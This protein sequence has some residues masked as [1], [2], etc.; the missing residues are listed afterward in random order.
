MKDPVFIVG[1]PR[2][3]TS[4]IY[5]T[6]MKHTEFQS[7]EICLEETGIFQ[8]SLVGHDLWMKQKNLKRYF[9]DEEGFD[10]FV[11]EYK[12]RFKY[13]IFLSKIPGSRQIIKRI[14]FLWNLTGNIQIIQLFFQESVKA[15]RCNRIA[16][17][18][19]GHLHYLTRILKAFPD[20]KFLIVVRHPIDVYTSY[21]RRARA[22]P[23][24]KWLAVSQNFFIKKYRKC[25]KDTVEA[26][27]NY[28]GNV[29]LVSYEDF[30]SSPDKK[31]KDIC[32]FLNIEFEN[33]PINGGEKSFNS[34]KPDPYLAKPISKETK[35]WNDYI[36]REEALNIERK[37]LNEMNILSYKQ[38]SG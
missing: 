21:V 32:E 33:E 19:P 36:S 20:A 37:L 6:L 23:E 18:T 24:M 30:V 14:E 11:N 28:D 8:K 17:K 15:R 9:I 13:Q 5:R 26:L 38:K 22:Q 29:F 4:L 12:S 34:W 7:K 3:G 31:F 2:S 16:E 1:P 35:K 25:V 27:K 10:C